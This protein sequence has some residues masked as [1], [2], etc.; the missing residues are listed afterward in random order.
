MVET[1]MKRKK[2]S[3]YKITLTYLL[4][5]FKVSGSGVVYGGKIFYIINNSAAGCLIPLKFRT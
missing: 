2:Y 3:N 5:T 4:Q 1:H